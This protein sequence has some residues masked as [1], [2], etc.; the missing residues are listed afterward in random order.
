MR[1]L[2]YKDIL[3]IVE[4]QN[5]LTVYD[6]G[7]IIES[8]L[9][10]PVLEVS[11]EIYPIPKFK[12]FHERTLNDLRS[13]HYN[14]SSQLLHWECQN[15]LRNVHQTFVR[16]REDL[17]NRIKNEP[18]FKQRND[19]TSVQYESELLQLVN[20]SKDFLMGLPASLKEGEINTVLEDLLKY[21]MYI[22]GKYAEGASGKEY[23]FSA[24]KRIKGL[25]AES[26][27]NAI[28]L[29]LST[30]N[31]A[32]LA[33]MINN[34]V[35]NSSMSGLTER[36][37]DMFLPLLPSPVRHPDPWARQYYTTVTEGFLVGTSPPTSSEL[38]QK[39]FLDAYQSILQS[40]SSIDQANDAILLKAEVCKL[41]GISLFHVE[42]LLM[43]V[44]D[45]QLRGIS[46]YVHAAIDDP[47]HVLHTI[48]IIPFVEEKLRQLS[49]LQDWLSHS[50]LPS[51]HIIY[52]YWNESTL[53]QLIQHFETNV[54]KGQLLPCQ[55]DLINELILLNKLSTKALNDLEQLS[56][57]HKVSRLFSCLVEK[58]YNF[59]VNSAYPRESLIQLAVQVKYEEALLTYTEIC[60]EVFLHYGTLN[61]LFLAL[62]YGERNVLLS[63]QSKIEAKLSPE[64][65][66]ENVNNFF[67]AY[68]D[69]NSYGDPKQQTLLRCAIR[70]NYPF[71]VRKLLAWSN[72]DLNAR[73]ARYYYDDGMEFRHLL[74][75]DS[76]LVLAARGG[77][78]EIVE[79]LLGHPQVSVNMEGDDENALVIAVKNNFTEIVK[80]LLAHPDIDVNCFSPLLVTVKQNQI[81]FTKLLLNHPKLDIRSICHSLLQINRNNEIVSL[82]THKYIQQ[83]ISCH[84][85]KLFLFA[86]EFGD[87][88][89]IN[90]YISQ[91]E[92]IIRIVAI[93][94]NAK[95]KDL[96]LSS[97][98]TIDRRYFHFPKDCCALSY[99]LSKGSNELVRVLLLHPGINIFIRL[100]GV[101]LFSWATSNLQETELVEL[102]R[103]EQQ[104]VKVHSIVKQ[105]DIN[106]FSDLLNQNLIPLNA[107]NKDGYTPLVLAVKYGQTEMV[108]L[109][110]SNPKVDV[111][112]RPDNHSRIALKVAAIEKQDKCLQLLLS[113]GN[114]LRSNLIKYDDVETIL[115]HAAFDVVK[116]HMN[117]FINILRE[118]RGFCRDR[119][120]WVAIKHNYVPIVDYLIRE[121]QVDLNT[122]YDH[123]DTALMIACK[124]GSPEMIECFLTKQERVKVNLANKNQETALILAIKKQDARIV[125]LLFQFVKL[126]L[127]LTVA[128]ETGDS[129]LMCAVRLQNCEIIQYLLQHPSIQINTMNKQSK[130]PLLIATELNALN[131]VQTL[132][133]HPSC[134]VNI[135]NA[136]GITPLMLSIQMQSYSL[137]AFYLSRQ[138]VDLH[139]INKINDSALFIAIK[140]RS[141]LSSDYTNKIE[142]DTLMKQM[143][144]MSTTEVVNY[145][146]AEMVT[147][148]MHAIESNDIKTV[149][150]LLQHSDLDLNRSDKHGD[151]SLMRACRKGNLLLIDLLLAHALQHLQINH[152]N[153]LGETALM[154]ALSHPDHFALQIMQKLLA[155]PNIVINCVTKSNETIFM[156]A[157]TKGLLQCVTLLGQ[158]NA[159]VETLNYCDQRG[160][161]AL[162][163]VLLQRNISLFQHLLSYP[164]ID[165]NAI[166]PIG[167]RS[168]NVLMLACKNGYEEELKLLLQHDHIQ[169]NLQN[170]MQET[171]LLLAI[172]SNYSHIVELLWQHATRIDVNM[173]DASQHTA[174]MAACRNGCE[175][176]VALLLQHAL[177][178]GIDLNAKNIHKETALMLAIEARAEKIVKMI[179][180]SKLSLDINHED[181]NGDTALLLAVG[182]NQI[183]IVKHLLL[184]PMIECEHTNKQKESISDLA[185][186]S[187]MKLL[188]KT[189]K[190]TQKL[191][192]YLRDKKHANT[193]DKLDTLISKYPDIDLNTVR[194]PETGMT[195]L[196]FAI[197]V[198]QSDELVKWILNREVNVNEVDMNG[199]SALQKAVIGNHK[200]IVK[201]LIKHASERLD[202]NMKY[203][204]LEETVLHIAVRSGLTKIVEKLLKHPTIDV[205]IVDGNGQTALEVAQEQKLSE[206]LE[207]LTLKSL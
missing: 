174:F 29:L 38:L 59:R 75:R 185:T 46:S 131:V 72:L 171:A 176:I 104:L 41:F 47:Q 162:I 157:C 134:D 63:Y 39:M 120:F 150:L 52:F 60:I 195:M 207:M 105:G 178:L 35:L 129:P 191:I 34:G 116:P 203:A 146:D 96:V 183:A 139:R 4:N 91:L 67:Y 130:S 147:A 175:E 84:S 6:R 153:A 202:I 30:L 33:N 28:E 159:I 154:I 127:N 45:E 144:Q 184:Y 50:Q 186:S 142:S 101:P 166:H 78:V 141:V 10:S 118:S 108:S 43:L 55:C 86:L 97:D 95:L 190:Q 89:V 81:E 20:E 71:I 177:V 172:R 148:L 94:I 121:S 100:D 15:K 8:I 62:L 48:S 87:I 27:T 76:A 11:L 17:K 156:R 109:L 187:A 58:E 198:Q 61:S 201:T 3:T 199:H 16:P 152:C 12:D 64:I 107:P 23:L 36:L 170:N 188:L 103:I 83:F 136:D 77:H 79:M 111:H 1:Y 197:T 115:T 22:C 151:T 164:S 21:V 68:R 24:I 57:N 180:N 125:K 145:S 106:Q 179:L 149:Q 204:P 80:L 206:I 112:A 74:E 168:Y 7:E 113:E 163:I 137:W 132:L 169:L 18:Y 40:T 110:L 173:V 32:R 181:Q 54:H 158:N 26:K 88:D 90:Q 117:D 124:F 31:D 167:Q 42:H 128:D 66:Q 194:D 92:D 9:I 119:I 196:M 73:P 122:I 5:S 138:D 2:L 51:K 143:I 123:S 135:A 65:I 155:Y 49:S 205:C 133:S 53:S 192:T 37:V 193:V 165:V 82:I 44:S 85:M 19:L 98:M 182:N 126:D 140:S 160:E 99:A 189:W 25:N 161:T 93:D 13:Q 70:Q 102:H 56:V 200:G 69:P 114:A 14:N